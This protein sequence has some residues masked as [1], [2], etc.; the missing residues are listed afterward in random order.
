MGI[1]YKPLFLLLVQKGLKKTDLYHL[2]NLTPN[3]V[4]RFAKGE[5]VSL[6]IIERICAALGCQPGDIV[7]YTPDKPEK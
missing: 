5:P 1:S 3:T 2:A 7:E 4:A 6:E